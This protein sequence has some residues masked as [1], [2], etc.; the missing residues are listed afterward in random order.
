MTYERIH[1][2]DWPALPG[3]LGMVA[4]FLG[5]RRVIRVAAVLI[6]VL[7]LLGVAWAT[8]LDLRDGEPVTALRRGLEIASILIG[9]IA[10]ELA[11]VRGSSPSVSLRVA[12]Y[13]ALLTWFAMF[14]WTVGTS[15]RWFSDASDFLLRG[16]M[17]T[18]IFSSAVSGCVAFATRGRTETPRSRPS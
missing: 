2:E 14:C 7:T 16:V 17:L 8:I 10:V 15:A 9:V 12:V 4:E 5:A 1:W 18:A 6:T 3:R 11:G 13:F